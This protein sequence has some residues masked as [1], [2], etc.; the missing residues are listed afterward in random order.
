MKDLAHLTVP[1]SASKEV[2]D[3]VA[4]LRQDK[5]SSEPTRV[6]LVLSIAER[7]NTATRDERQALIQDVARAARLTSWTSR[8]PDHR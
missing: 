6:E 2:R 4:A 3:L 7:W 5:T 8:R 1:R